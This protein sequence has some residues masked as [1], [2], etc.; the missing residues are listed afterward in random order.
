MIRLP[1]SMSVGTE[2]VLMG[3]SKDKTLFA[4]DLADYAHTINYEI[5]TSITPRLLRRYQD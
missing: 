1:E 5:L 3:T 2:V 4:T